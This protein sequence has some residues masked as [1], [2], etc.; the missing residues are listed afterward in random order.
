M[1]IIE[2][3]SLKPYNTFKVDAKADFL[4]EIASQDDVKEAIQFA[5]KHQLQTLVLGG[6][7]NILFTQNFTGAVFFIHNKGIEQV[8]EEENF[9]WVEAAAGENWHQF[10]L[11]CV[12]QNWQGVENLSLIPGTVGAAPVQNI[13]AYG[14]EIR[15]VVESVEAIHKG[16]GE[17]KIFTNEEC[18]FAYRNSIFK[19]ELKGQY[20]ITKVK[21]KLRKKP[22]Y[23]ISYGAISSLLADKE[24]SIKA[25][26]DAVTGIRERKLPNPVLIGNCGSFFKNPIVEKAFY[27]K[28]KGSYP[29]LVAYPQHDKMKLAAGWLIEQSGWKGKRIGEVGTYEKQALVIVNHG[30]ATGA[31]A[32]S[33]AQKIRNVVHDKFGV[34]IE[35]EVNVL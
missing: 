19:A 13:G 33:F 32:K 8:G 30:N 4:L 6:G 26:S 17:T 35:P 1:K 11:Y 7:S 3:A 31:E 28:L 2:N 12:E 21:F 16:S 34:F 29:N 20:I 23:N 10:V 9:V 27:E 25:I 24:I 5:K 15:E 22:I 14:V 18:R